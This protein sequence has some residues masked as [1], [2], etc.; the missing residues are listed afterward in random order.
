MDFSS[1]ASAVSQRAARILGSASPVQARIRMAPKLDTIARGGNAAASVTLNDFDRKSLILSTEPDA[2][3]MV[4][5]D[6]MGRTRASCAIKAETT[7]RDTKAKIPAASG[8]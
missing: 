7:T 1:A 2:N 3:T 6:R 5:P 4:P 8:P